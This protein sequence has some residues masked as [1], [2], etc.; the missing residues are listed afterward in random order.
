MSTETVPMPIG[1]DHFQ[2]QVGEWADATFPESTAHTI[3][4]HLLREAAELCFATMPEGQ[5]RADLGIALRGDVR[6]VG[7]REIFLKEHADPLATP[8]EAADVTLL[9][10]HLAHKAGFSLLAVAHTKHEANR[11]RRWGDPDAAGVVEHLREEG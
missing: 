2:R 1:L 4:R 7:V 6:R 3:A 8:T 11:A 5:K 9:A 10:L